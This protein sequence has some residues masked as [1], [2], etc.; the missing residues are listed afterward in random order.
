MRYT[1]FA[2]RLGG[3]FVVRLERQI[4]SSGHSPAK[5]GIIL[6]SFGEASAAPEGMTPYNVAKLSISYP[7]YAHLP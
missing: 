3:V 5:C 1:H 2:A 6:L 7:L 4:H